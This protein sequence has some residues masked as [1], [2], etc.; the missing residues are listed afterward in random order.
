MK[1]V[2]AHSRDGQGPETWE[3]LS[4]HLDRVARYASSFAATFGVGGWGE[5]AGRLHDLGKSSDAFQRRLAGGPKVD[6]T[7]AGGK[8]ALQRAGKAAGRILAYPVVGHHSG[9]LD[10]SK[11]D[12]RLKRSDL[13]PYSSTYV[14]PWP[15]LEKP[16]FE[17]EDHFA[18]QFFVRMLFSCLAD[19]DFLATEAFYDPVKASRR[20]ESID[21]RT[22]EEKLNARLASFQSDTLINRER[23]AILNRERSAILERCRTM[24]IEAPGLFSLTVPTGG[25]KTLSSLAFAL[26]HAQIHGLQRVIY[27]IPYTSIIEQTAKVF[28]DALGADA[29]LEHH[30]NHSHAKEVPGGDPDDATM[31]RLAEENWDMPVVVTT[32]V[33]F[34]ESLYAARGSRC[35]KLHNLARSVIILD[36]AQMLPVEYLQPCLEA[37]RELMR[38]YGASVVLCTATQPALRRSD[39]LPIGFDAIREIMPDPV[40]LYERLRRVALDPLGPLDDEA[41]AARLANHDQV[42]AVVNT[43]DHARRLYE[44]LA[45]EPGAFHLSARMCPAH[46]RQILDLIRKTL[47]EKAPCRLVSTQLIE[48]GVDVDF[49]IAYRATAGLD[50]LIQTA[51]RC[52][53][54]GGQTLGTVHVFEPMGEK[55][56]GDRQRR[57]EIARRVLETET[58]PLAPR[59]VERFFRELYNLADLDANQ[60]LDALLVDPKTLHFDFAEAAERFRFIDSPTESVI[61]PFDE[62]A[63]RLIERLRHTEWPAGL[64]R[65]LQPYTVQVYPAEVMALDRTG[66]LEIVQDRFKVLSD[67]GFYDDKL[68]LQPQAGAKLDPER[69][70]H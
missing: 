4:D 28:R 22:L 10:G 34:F 52:N 51:G 62:A 2:Y 57:A 46:R 6:H 13:P 39:W 48:A 20:S 27:V 64:L 35:R 29:V 42:L 70:I 17:P 1:T 53:R 19:A 66:K 44:R 54:E 68:G 41:L 67:R 40:G 23:S 69:M 63:N 11:L 14:E 61:V 25:G 50:S 31:L 37:L 9:L 18:A 49:P 56:R 16:P 59:A 8:E 3:P 12:E 21:L 38:G 30:S 24:A 43:R 60:V 65:A 45:A 32:S 55:R 7:T 26:R 5:I 36:E 33:Q 15:I 58:D 47:E